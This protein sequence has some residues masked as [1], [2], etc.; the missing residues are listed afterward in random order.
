MCQVTDEKS[1]SVTGHVW[2]IFPSICSILSWFIHFQNIT[3]ETNQKKESRRRSIDF[4]WLEKL[5][6][7]LSVITGEMEDGVF[8]CL[9]TSFL[10]FQRFSREK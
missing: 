3:N 10:L 2:D 5:L 8:F 4:S 9:E 7:I 1:Q 6:S